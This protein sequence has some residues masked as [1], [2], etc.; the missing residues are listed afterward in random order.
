MIKQI[1][2]KHRTWC[3]VG[4]IVVAVILVW[5]LWGGI[6]A[7][8]GTLFG[9]GQAYDLIR[10]QSKADMTRIQKQSQADRET[11]A[12]L[13]QQREKNARDLE[14]Y[15]RQKREEKLVSEQ[16][17]REGVS[18]AEQKAKAVVD[19]AK[20]TEDLDRE[21]DAAIDKHTRYL[22]KEGGFVR[23][24]LLGAMVLAWLILLLVCLPIPGFSSPAS[25]PATQVQ[26]E[27]TRKLLVLLDRYKLLV[28]KL[29]R[30]IEIEK[31]ECRQIV[32]SQ[33][34]HT[35][36][37]ERIVCDGQAKK[38]QAEIRACMAKQ[39]AVAQVRCPP[40]WPHA[41]VSGLVV[42]GVCGG[43]VG[44]REATR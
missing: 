11:Q 14:A 37:L 31:K 39:L 1:W 7:I 35:R 12:K 18:I 8:I 27:R 25:M 16:Q 41:L 42:A 10:K 19:R 40:C 17:Y 13:D 33:S 2:E 34:L 6:A 5:V 22:D 4:I 9:S 29:K 24:G 23:L 28:E 26:K 43:I 36:A 32:A 3:I 44:I 38:Y 15:A 21:T 20:T 30:D